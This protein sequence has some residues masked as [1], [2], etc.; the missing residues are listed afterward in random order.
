MQKFMKKQCLT[1][2]AGVKNILATWKLLRLCVFS[3]LIQCFAFYMFIT[4]Y[5]FV[6]SQLMFRF[7]HYLGA[8]S[9]PL[10]T[11]YRKNTA[12]SEGIS[13]EMLTS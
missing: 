9:V 13:G 7:L 3:Q 12:E 11:S 2:L 8:L 5:M 4:L 1:M 10:H 6:A